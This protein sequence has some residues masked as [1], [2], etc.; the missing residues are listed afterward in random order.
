MSCKNRRERGRGSVS[1]L[2]KG[3]V[4]VVCFAEHEVIAARITLWGSACQGGLW[5][6]GF[7]SSGRGI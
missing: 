3:K 4:T 2:V 1:A 6:P 5:G 7:L